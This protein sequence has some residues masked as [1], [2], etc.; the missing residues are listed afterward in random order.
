M[1]G[2]LFRA[3]ILAVLALGVLVVVQPTAAATGDVLRELTATTNGNFSAPGGRGVA[4]DGANLYY[5]FNGI[6]SIFEMSTAGSFV[7]EIPTGPAIQG[8]PLAWDGTALWTADYSIG[9]QFLYQVDAPTGAILSSCNYA[10]ANPTSPAITGEFG[11]TFAPDGLDWTGSSLW[12]SSDAQPGNYVAELDPTSCNIL[13]YFQPPVLAGPERSCG[14]SG[15]ALVG[16]TL[17]HGYPCVPALAQT[18]LAGNALSGYFGTPGRAEEDLALD[19]VTFA[20]KCALWANESS[21]S[22]P[23]HIT[24]YEI[25]CPVTYTVTFLQP[26]DQS[27]DPANP[28]KN[29][30][31]NGRVIPV[32]VQIHSSDGTDVTNAS[33]PTVTMTVSHLPSCASSTSDAVETYAPAG[34][35]NTD[36]LF[37][38][39]GMDW[40]YNWDTST[41]GLTSGDCYRINIVLNGTQIASAFAIYQPVR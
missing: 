21:G 18:D 1:K 22:G 38:W 31:K 15:L 34:S 6:H 33:N 7:G 25:P 41:S 5:T 28:V 37:R 13:R 11:L 24:A 12:L 16:S 23:S 29:V 36:G 10:A 39:D 30:G 19:K 8:G 14:T 40:A 27:T 2:R 26:L 35:A 3:A 4:F 32:K 9:N 17:W 20:P